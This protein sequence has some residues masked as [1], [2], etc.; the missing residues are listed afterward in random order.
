M[1][2][3]IFFS[4][5]AIVLGLSFAQ[6]QGLQFGIK[7]GANIVKIDGVPFKNQF[8]YGYHLGGFVEIKLSD[9]LSLQPEV[10]WMQS[11]TTRDSNLSNIYKSLFNLNNTPNIKLNYIAIPVLL[12][13]KVANILT[14]QAGPQF[15]IVIDQ[16]RTVLANGQQAF[17]TGDFSML[18][19]AQLKLFG[20]QVYGR[21]AIGLNNLNDVATPDSWKSQTIQVGLGFTF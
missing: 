17:K 10:L 20:V 8:D 13:Y 16:S 9:K 14:L 4:F 11:Q 5:F 7:G 2:S 3:K 12:N 21:Y 15:G 18:A 6:A 1:K 19:G